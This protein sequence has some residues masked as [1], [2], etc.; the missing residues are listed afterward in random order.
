[1]RRVARDSVLAPSRSDDPHTRPPP[2]LDAER[3]LI[4]VA[5]CVQGEVE[6]AMTC[7]P[8]LDY[9]RTAPAWE[10]SADRHQ[11]STQDDADLPRLLLVS[12]LNMGIEIERADVQRGRGRV[13][14]D[15]ER[16][17]AT[18]QRL[19]QLGRV[20]RVLDQSTPEQVVYES[21]PWILAHR[22]DRNAP[23]FPR[24]VSRPREGRNRAW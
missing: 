12:D 14:T 7:H 1:M 16:D 8:S 19:A 23:G 9:G 5:E 3:V 15:I 13:E 22:S 18:V 4:R 21:H 20:G 11:A 10:L 6:L 17:R 2:D 24:R